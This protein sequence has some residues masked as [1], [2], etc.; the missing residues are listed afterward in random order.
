MERLT[1]RILN[2]LQFIIIIIII[3][4][5]GLRYVFGKILSLNMCFV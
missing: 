3:F 5:L 1:L 4:L 2:T